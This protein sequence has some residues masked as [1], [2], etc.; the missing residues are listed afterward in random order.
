MDARKAAGAAAQAVRELPARPNRCVQ[1]DAARA[2][3]HLD[4]CRVPGH[5]PAAYLTRKLRRHAGCE[6]CAH[7]VA[8]HAAASC[9]S[10]LGHTHAPYVRAAPRRVCAASHTKSHCTCIA[11]V[12]PPLGNYLQEITDVVNCPPRPCKSTI[13]NIQKKLSTLSFWRLVPTGLLEHHANSRPGHGQVTYIISTPDYLVTGTTS[14]VQ[15]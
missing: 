9:G 5:T 7:G 1:L 13:M 15:Q 4:V 10:V 2:R 12:R 11:N 3:T 14:C 8:P 6:V